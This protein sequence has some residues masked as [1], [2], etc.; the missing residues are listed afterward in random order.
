[1]GHEYRAKEESLKTK[2]LF[3]SFYYY[4]LRVG[5]HFVHYVFSLGSEGYEVGDAEE[6]LDQALMVLRVFGG[7]ET[8][9]EKST[10]ET[11]AGLCNSQCHG[12]TMTDTVDGNFSDVVW[13]IVQTNHRHVTPVIDESFCILWS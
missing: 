9:G 12:S 6:V 5:K 1:L 2:K 4:K 13:D 11:R 10:L 8:M 7:W 3:A